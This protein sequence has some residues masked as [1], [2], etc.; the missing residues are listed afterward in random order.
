MDS[1][2]CLDCLEKGKT[3]HM[4]RMVGRPH[5]KCHD[6]GWIGHKDKFFEV[7]FK[8]RTHEE[9]FKQYVKERLKDKQ[10]K[11]RKEIKSVKNAE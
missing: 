1:P 4:Y 9:N 8:W 3:G 6:C 7:E 5:F 10:E 2:R 11:N